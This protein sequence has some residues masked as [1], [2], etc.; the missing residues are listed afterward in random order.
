[1]FCL[2]VSCRTNNA[3]TPDPDA[4][5]Y[6]WHFA[7]PRDPEPFFWQPGPTPGCFEPGLG[8]VTFPEPGS[9]VVLGD[10]RVQ[11]SADG[12]F[13]IGHAASGDRVLAAGAGDGMWLQA[14][15]SHLE[16]HEH[17][18]SFSVHETV[19]FR[20]LLPR[21]DGWWTDGRTMGTTI[22]FSDPQPECAQAL[23]SMAF[24]EVEPGHLEFR[25]EHLH[26][27]FSRLD[28]R[29]H[30][31]TEERILGMG[32][33]FPHDTLNL[34]GRMIPVLSQEGG[35]GRGHGVISPAVNAASP[36]S[37][38]S[39]DST[40]HAAPHYLTTRLRSVFLE[41]SEYAEFD[42]RAP[43]TIEIRLHSPAMHGRILQG[44]HPLELVER[45]TAYAGRMPPL[46]PWIHDGAIV[47]L[48]RDT[49]SSLQVVQELLS[50]GVR[51]AAVW[52]Q[53]WSG[54]VDTF[55]GEQ[56]L[57]NWVLN[58]DFHPRWDAFVDTLDSLGIRVLCY[59]N[60]MFVPLPED[61]ALRDLY[62][63]GLEN[64]YFV[65]DAAG[66]VLHLPV[67]AF[68]VALLDLTHEGA[69]RWMKDIL[70]EEVLGN[71]RCSGWMV[72]F[73]EAL[74]F[75]AQLASGVDAATFHNLYPVEWMRLN[76]E[77]VEEA[78]RL[79]DVLLFNR[80]GFTRTPSVSLLSWQGD[81]LTT[82]D[83][84]DGLVS[85]LHGLVSGGFSGVALNHS[86]TGGYT[87]LSQFGLGYS[88]EAELL[89]RWTEMNA[90]TAVLRTHEGN[91][92]PENAQIYD[93]AE[94][95]SHFARMS[96]VYQSLAFY[97]NQLFA[98][99]SGKG[100]PLVRHLWLHFPDDPVVRL[101]DDQFL[102]GADLLVAP[103]K[104]KCWTWP[105]CP[106]D[107]DVVFPPGQWVHL[108]TGTVHGSGTHATSGT[109]SAPI[110]Q[111]A[112]FY[113]KDSAVGEQFTENLRQAGVMVPFPP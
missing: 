108:W 98:E 87:S 110:G 64:G 47:A 69:R 92:P 83:K 38:G 28:L 51:I 71:G 96:K 23:I 5:P 15:R 49:D 88:R 56:V 11:L 45:F 63:E 16:V 82:W 80:S 41:N 59:V 107:R 55:I 62:G 43:D 73:A 22:G 25:A 77:A 50:R 61:S 78:E 4:G 10:F 93:D 27:S 76:R 109:V 111:P 29:L 97:R 94:S 9:S 84:Y 70:I 101:V 24:C 102:L 30:S 39:E 113:R 12:N 1:M 79:G 13:S 3:A 33:Q 66:E 31:D 112:V 7:P 95:M 100:W 17:Q 21:V 52:N 99:A 35:V 90:F 34:K 54:R 106:Y 75:D 40:Y 6:P 85:A 14:A 32:M 19:H 68:D 44:E 46:P 58:R 20:C 42:F 18:G 60:P 37:A 103:V 89:K 57:W 48:A 36:G 74:P 72:D 26:G 67:T 105:W 86:D 65:R 104:N 91:Q 81:Q 53:T 8:S 2:A